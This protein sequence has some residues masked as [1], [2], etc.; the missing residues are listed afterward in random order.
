M[1]SSG[2]GW[3][4]GRLPPDDFDC[5]R[6]LNIVLVDV[7]QAGNAEY[8]H[9]LDEGATLQIEVRDS[10]VVFSHVG[11]DIG[12]M[13]PQHKQIAACIASG[14]RYAASISNISGTASA[15][16]ISVLLVGTPPRT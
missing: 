7:P 2:T 9:S 1:S 5:P 8:A 3:D 13:P 11:H 14:W 10:V 15:P 16:R 4:S 12:Y 6:R